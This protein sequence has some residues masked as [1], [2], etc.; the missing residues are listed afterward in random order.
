MD[1]NEFA[2]EWDRV[3]VEHL[4]SNVLLNSLKGRITFVLGAAFILNRLEESNEDYDELV[5]HLRDELQQ[6]YDGLP[7]PDKP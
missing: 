1:K 5:D 4:N 7:W 6:Y 2:A 3:F